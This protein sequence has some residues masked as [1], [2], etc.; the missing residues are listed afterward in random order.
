MLL[1][2]LLLTHLFGWSFQEMEDQ[3]DLSLVLRWFCRFSWRKTPD[4]TTQQPE[5]R[6][7]IGSS[8]APQSWPG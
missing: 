7:Y 5:T 8:S 1:R 6:P 2:L 4:D 3:V